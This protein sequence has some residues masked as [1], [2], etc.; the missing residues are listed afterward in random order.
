MNAPVQAPEV[1]DFINEASKID[2]K[3]MVFGDGTFQHSLDGPRAYQ[4]PVDDRHGQPF[5]IV[6]WF[7]ANPSEWWTRRGLAAILGEPA[8]LIAEGRG[9]PVNLYPSPAEW[10]HSWDIT[11]ICILDWNANLR[12]A[13]GR[14]PAVRCQSEMLANELHRRLQEQTKPSFIITVEGERHAA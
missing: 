7:Q 12:F 11:G 14:V 6:A 4:I 2:P 3:I 8:L 13:L 1:S 10:L 5:D 9:K